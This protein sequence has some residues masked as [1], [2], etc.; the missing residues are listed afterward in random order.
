MPAIESDRIY[1]KS[2]T[3]QILRVS[4]VTLDRMYRQGG[5]PARLKLSPARVGYYGHAIIKYLEPTAA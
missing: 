3:A 5:G 1:T 2:E 4:E